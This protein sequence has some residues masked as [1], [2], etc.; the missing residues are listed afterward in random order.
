MRVVA[1]WAKWLIAI[2]LIIQ[3]GIYANDVHTRM[4]AI[5][6]CEWYPVKDRFERPKPPHPYSGRYCYVAQHTVLLQLFDAEGRLFAERMYFHLDGGVFVWRTNLEE[7][8]VSLFYD[9]DS[10][11]GEILV[12]PT[13]LDRLRAKLP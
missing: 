4:S 11:G 6:S 1:T 7:R 13:L 5:D 12:P 9:S 2:A 3:L 10:D 8:V